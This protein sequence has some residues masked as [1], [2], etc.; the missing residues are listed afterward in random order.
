MAGDVAPKCGTRLCV[1]PPA[2][3]ATLDVTCPT[4][5]H[6]RWGAGGCLAEVAEWEL[7]ERSGAPPRTSAALP[8]PVSDQLHH[9]CCLA[10]PQ[11]RQ[12]SPGPPGTGANAA[13]CRRCRTVPAASPQG[14]APG[15]AGGCSSWHG[16][17]D[18]VPDA[19][20][21]VG[22][23][24]HHV[25][26]AQHHSGRS[27]CG[28]SAVQM[29]GGC[30]MCPA[31]WSRAVAVH[32]ATWRLPGPRALPARCPAPTHPPTALNPLAAL[33]PPLGARRWCVSRTTRCWRCC[34]ATPSASCCCSAS[35]RC[36]C[37]TPRCTAGWRSA[38]LLA[39]ARCCTRP[40]SPSFQSLAA[41]TC[42]SSSTR[43]PPSW[44]RCVAGA[45]QGRLSRSVQPVLCHPCRSLASVGLAVPLRARGD[46]RASL[47][48][49]PPDPPHPHPPPAARSCCTSATK[50]AVRWAP[51]AA[52]AA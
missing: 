14:A 22:P 30:A 44:K 1:A 35:G 49:R 21:D 17:Q 32:Q 24:A 34:W 37:T 40:C 9:G 13:A 10:P 6:H 19:G 11:R 28:E 39:R 12:D 27:L 23:H 38:S 43:T 36:G 51:S 46:W 31:A 20:G 16:I 15:G 33:N 26:G 5:D 4:T 2:G 42:R 7:A 52:R 29:C 18:A 47:V 45:G 41:T 48:P 50:R 3:H 8:C 25:C